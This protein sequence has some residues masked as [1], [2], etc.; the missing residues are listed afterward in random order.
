MRKGNRVQT[1]DLSM[2]FGIGT[3]LAEALSNK[4]GTILRANGSYAKVTFDNPGTQQIS[5]PPWNN[6][7]EWFSIYND[8][9]LYK[10]VPI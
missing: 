10:G 1:K 5:A 4:T 7:G 2:A 9:E 6:E 3:R 8:L